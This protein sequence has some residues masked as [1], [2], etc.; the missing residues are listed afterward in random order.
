MSE[1][2]YIIEEG[3]IWLLVA[4]LLASPIIV[5]LALNRWLKLKR[6]RIIA[7]CLS[8]SICLC[9]FVMWLVAFI[10]YQKVGHDDGSSVAAGNACDQFS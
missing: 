5:A 3:V 7:H 8:L 1:L 10:S 6:W 4:L 9:L 2:Y